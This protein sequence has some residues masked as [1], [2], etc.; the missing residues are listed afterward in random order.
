MWDRLD[1][2]DLYHSLYYKIIRSDILITYGF[3]LGKRI[4]M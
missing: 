1:F 3:K 2:Y 4:V